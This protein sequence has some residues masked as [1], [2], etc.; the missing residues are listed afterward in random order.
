[1]SR[2]ALTFTTPKATAQTAM[3]EAAQ[4]VEAVT[5]LHDSSTTNLRG[6]F[7]CVTVRFEG[8]NEHEA[9]ATGTVAVCTLRRD[10]LIVDAWHVHTA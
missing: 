4:A 10:A 1:M 8:L 5:I 7:A 9:R 3:T 6:Q 2:Y